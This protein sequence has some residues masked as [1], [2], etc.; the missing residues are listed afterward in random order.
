MKISERNKMTFGQLFLKELSQEDA[1]AL[2]RAIVD[3]TD[4][5]PSTLWRWGHD[6][7]PAFPTQHLIRRIIAEQLGIVTTVGVLFPRKKKVVSE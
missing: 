1:K 4:V 6:L 2:R 5:C 7:M 3:E